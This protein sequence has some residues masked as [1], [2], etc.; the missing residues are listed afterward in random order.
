MH[1]L[2]MTNN[3]PRRRP[4]SPHLGDKPPTTLPVVGRGGRLH[5][6]P[7]LRE[8]HR[9]KRQ[10]MRRHQGGFLRQHHRGQHVQQP[11]GHQRRLLQLTGR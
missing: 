1:T 2:P 6:Q 4:S 9:H 10:R 11:A 5:Q 8:R 3:R 7:G